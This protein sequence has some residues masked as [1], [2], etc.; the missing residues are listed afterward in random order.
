MRRK[1]FSTF[2]LFIS[3][4]LLTYNPLRVIM[5]LRLRDNRKNERR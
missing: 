2:R 3:S 1:V 4:Y 5:I